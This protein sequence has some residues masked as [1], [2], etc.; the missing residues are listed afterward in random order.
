MLDLAL[1]PTAK[2]AAFTVCQ[3]TTLLAQRFLL[4]LLTAA[5]SIKY[6]PQRGSC[7]PQALETGQLHSEAD[8]RAI[9]ELAEAQVRRNLQA[10]ESADMPAGERYQ[11]AHLEKVILGPGQVLLQIR[12]V[13]RAGSTELTLPLR[14]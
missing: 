4:E 8:L 5:G 11:T 10:E 14:L 12:I 3:G 6:Q 2:T 9:F 7:F 13:A 1:W